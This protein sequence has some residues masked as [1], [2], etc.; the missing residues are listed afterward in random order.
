MIH[1]FL[2]LLNYVRC[3]VS[4]FM[5]C[6]PC[7]FMVSMILIM[8]VV[9]RYMRQGHALMPRGRVAACPAAPSCPW[10]SLLQHHQPEL[11]QSDRLS[12][13]LLPE[14]LHD[15]DASDY[16]N[17]QGVSGTPYECIHYIWYLAKF[18]VQSDETAAMI[19]RRA[20]AP[21]E[22]YITPTLP[23]DAALQYSQQARSKTTEAAAK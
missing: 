19:R 16:C 11:Q 4:Q 5:Q 15:H 6:P 12:Y 9:W 18:L 7:C 20:I 10:D 1:K 21:F 3:D 22:N 17:N 13:K 8:G 14:N 23:K 2:D